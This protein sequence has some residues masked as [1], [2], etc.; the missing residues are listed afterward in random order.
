[1]FR[2]DLTKAAVIAATI[3]AF[4]AK[5]YCAWTTIGEEDVLLFFQYARSV[6]EHGLAAT[7]AA[8][9]IFNHTP[10]VA[11]IATAAYRIAQVSNIPFPFLIRL[12]G[13][14][15]DVVVIL[16][17]LAWRE[18]GAR[19]P[20]WSLCLF[21]LS[22][23][24]FMISGYHGNVDS[25]LAMFVVLA[26]YTCVIERPLPCA[27]FL[28]LGCN[29]K[30]ISLLF[31]PLFFFFWLKRG[32]G[33]RFLL[34]I[35][36]ICLIGWLP[37]LVPEPALFVKNVLSY[38]SYW[39]MWGISY[40][41]RATGI[42]AFGSVTPIDFNLAQTFVI[43]TLKG[44]IILAVAIL[45]W[46]R[47]HLPRETMPVTVAYAW[48]IFFVFAPSA[49]PQYMAWPAAFIFLSSLQ[50][51]IWLTAATS[52]FLFFFY[53][54]ISHGLPWNAGISTPD[55]VPYWLPWGIWPWSVFLIGL[56]QIW[57]KADWL[58]PSLESF[59]RRIRKSN[60]PLPC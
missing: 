31:I 50:W 32:S 39:G 11:A 23:V 16:V 22:P 17:L 59:L 15:S 25:V 56:L 51:Y 4:L 47:R 28:G 7:Y 48:T 3:V 8:I 54:S 18:K 37:A 45:G 24:S 6:L 58:T 14:C 44:F 26:T 55:M 38:S 20:A 40:W 35:A 53:N 52:L 30:I 10:L 42:A 9:P 19:L 41:L 46:Q 33:W 27:L 2:S 49:C 29:V 21:A 13:I 1:M 5:C 36:A 57:K 43:Q 60:Q 12:P 34:A